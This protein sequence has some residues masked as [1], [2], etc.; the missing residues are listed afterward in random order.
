MLGHSTEVPVVHAVLCCAAR[1]TEHPC[2]GSGLPQAGVGPLAALGCPNNMYEVDM[3]SPNANK[4]QQHSWGL[5][6]SIGDQEVE[7][8]G[9]TVC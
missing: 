4:V 6:T 2:P 3:L 1:K 7:T 5:G 8:K 9:Q